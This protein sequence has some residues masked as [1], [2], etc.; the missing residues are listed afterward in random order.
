MEILA[1]LTGQELVYERLSDAVGISKDT[2]KSWRGVLEMG[3]IIHLL[4]AFYNSAIKRSIKRP[5]LY[6]CDT[7]L[8]CYLAKVFDPESLRVG[9]LNGPMVETYI[10]NEILK[11]YSNNSEK[12][13]FYYYRD[14]NNNEIDLIVLRDG[15]LT[16]IECK[17][18]M[19]YNASDVKAFSRI[20]GG[21]Y[22]IAPSC[23][24]CLTE[25]AYPLKDGVYAIPVTSI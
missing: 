7:G 23:I 2:V 10:V 22:E 20:K 9:Y 14:T 4:P 12:A 1:S 8:A 18:G 24:I 13:G 21:Q 11:S 16:L 5:K 19:S 15:R 25:Q 17:A 3:G 6:F